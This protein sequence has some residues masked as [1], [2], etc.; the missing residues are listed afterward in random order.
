MNEKLPADVICPY[1]KT[2]LELEKEEQKSGKFTC[3]NC[4]KEVTESVGGNVMS[5]VLHKCRVKAI[6][7]K[8]I[9]VNLGVKWGFSRRGILKVFGDRLECGNWNIPYSAIT[10]AVLRSMPWLLTKAHVLVVRTAET[11]YQFGLNPSSFWRGELPFTVK[12]QEGGLF[13]T[14]VNVVRIIIFAA[15][16]IA[17][18]NSLME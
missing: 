16:L 5:D 3:P 18:L 6:R 11:T 7:S 9:S 10:E 8:G 15:F 14:V 1:C 12:R 4:N 13:W 2:E 17:L